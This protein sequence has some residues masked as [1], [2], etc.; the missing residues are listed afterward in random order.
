MEVK[1][2]H[3]SGLLSQNVWGAGLESS[4]DDI[5]ADTD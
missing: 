5:E 4:T 1:G 3:H 2:A